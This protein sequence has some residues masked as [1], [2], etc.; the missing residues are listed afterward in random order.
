MMRG[1]IMIAA[2]TLLAL[3]GPAVAQGHPDRPDV[4]MVSDADKAMN[5]A[6]DKAR[7]ELPTFYKHLAKPAADERNFSV[8]FNLVP[9]GDAEFIWARDLEWINGK[10][11]GTLSNVPIAPEYSQGQR[12][13]IPQADIIDWGY[14]KGDVMQG[15]YTTRVLLDIMPASDAAR[16][17]EAFGW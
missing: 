8:K 2:S 14:M 12:L 1:I 5:A 7:A 16:L 6:I 13:L 3:S 4:V 17:R 15:N 9:D 10:L 11:Y